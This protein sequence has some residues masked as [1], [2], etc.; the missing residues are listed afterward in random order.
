M[1]LLQAVLVAGYGLLALIW[2][3]L[4]RESWRYEP[5]FSQKAHG[6]G[7]G[8]AI[9]KRTVEAHGGGITAACAEGTGLA[10]EIT[11]PLERTPV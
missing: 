11:L 8:L 5:F 10:F 9:A 3:V 1:S 4:A 7:L 6:T 2:G